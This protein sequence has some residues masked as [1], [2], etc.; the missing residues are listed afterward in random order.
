MIRDYYLTQV[1]YERGYDKRPEV[2]RNVN[3]WKDNLLALYQKKKYLDQQD[4][5]GKKDWK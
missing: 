3:M 2:K 5:K 1:A 4:L